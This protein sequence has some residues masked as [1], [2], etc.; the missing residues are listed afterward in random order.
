M[1]E[2][3]PVVLMSTSMGNIRI[4]LD[5]ERLGQRSIREGFGRAARAE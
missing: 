1:A 2:K 3:N 4:E 5:A